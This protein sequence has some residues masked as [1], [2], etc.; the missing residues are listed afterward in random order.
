[1]EADR[2]PAE[3]ERPTI[4][5][6]ARTGS[7]RLPGKVLA[8]LC[9]RPVLAW[10]L[11]RLA[12]SERAGGLVVA[13]TTLSEDDPVAELSERR[14]V[15]VFRGHPT[16]VLARYVAAARWLDADAIV[17][18]SA[19]CPLIDHVVADTVIAAFERSEADLVQNHR[20]PGWPF[21]SATEVI[22]AGCLARLDGEA[23][24]EAQREHV[25]MHAYGNPDRF[26]IDH[27][28][29]PPELR[30]PEL[31]LCVDTAEDLER[32]RELCAAFE[33]PG[34]TPLSEIVAASPAAGRSA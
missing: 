20:E 6:Q 7:A 15:G 18:I 2:L 25:T 11:D 4:V 1:M 30:G 19:D 10:L 3:R 28:P 26:A 8:D 24:D 21:G 31:R 9:G 29:P 14:G 16:D 12:P 13:T 27:V 32:L 33:G 23:R 22:T 5:I 17:R 34:E